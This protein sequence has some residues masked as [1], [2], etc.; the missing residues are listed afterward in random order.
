MRALAL[1]VVA[2]ATLLVSVTARAQTYDPSYPVCLQLYGGQAGYID[3][4]YTSLAQCNATASGRSAQCL[5]NPFF[6]H[7]NEGRIG[8]RAVR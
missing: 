7:P 6:S 3:C 8:R 2:V 5:I 1:M 4:S